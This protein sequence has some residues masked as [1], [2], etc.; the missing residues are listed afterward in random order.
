MKNTGQSHNQTNTP[1]DKRLASNNPRDRLSA[2]SPPGGRLKPFPGTSSNSD[3][4]WQNSFNLQFNFLSKEGAALG[5]ENPQVNNFL[6]PRVDKVQNPQMNPQSTFNSQQTS[7]HSLSDLKPTTGVSSKP[8]LPR[9]KRPCLLGSPGLPPPRLQTNLMSINQPVTP[10]FK[11]VINRS[12]SPKIDSSLSQLINEI[13]DVRQEQEELEEQ[14]EPV[15]KKQIQE[16]RNYSLKLEEDKKRLEE[17]NKRL[18]QDK[19][20]GEG[21]NKECNCS[22]VYNRKILYFIECGKEFLCKCLV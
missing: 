8:S 3:N 5:N 21:G 20:L 13:P 16:L 6:N 14:E 18:E 11:P 12:I 10:T 17:D 4:D 19:R 22:K 7:S 1:V 2:S 9:S 15:W